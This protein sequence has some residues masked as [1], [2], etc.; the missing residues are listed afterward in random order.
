M[1]PGPATFQG[2]VLMEEGGDFPVNQPPKSI[3]I[4]MGEFSKSALSSNLFILSDYSSN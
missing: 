4:P 3:Y 2:F 1:C